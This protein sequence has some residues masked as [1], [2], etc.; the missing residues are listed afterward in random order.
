LRA[1]SIYVVRTSL[2]QYFIPAT[3]NFDLKLASGRNR[4][5]ARFEGQVAQ[6]GDT[7]IDLLNFWKGTVDSNVVDFD[8]PSVLAVPPVLINSVQTDRLNSQIGPANPQVYKSIRDAGNWKNPYLV[9]RRE[10]IEVIARGLGS[11]RQTVP[12]SDLRR[13]LVEL[14]VSAWPYGRIVAMQDINLRSVDLGDEEPIAGN[15]SIALATLKK[16]GIAVDRWPS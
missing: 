5:A 16:L 9:V 1:G 12:A 7:D 2:N 6:G 8:V 15:R 3:S 13:T 4:I 14:P 10:G 11:G